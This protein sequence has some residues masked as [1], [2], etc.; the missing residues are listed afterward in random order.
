[1]GLLA[2]AGVVMAPAASVAAGSTAIGPG[3]QMTADRDENLA[4]DLDAK[5]FPTKSDE[6]NSNHQKQ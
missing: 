6:L 2:L 3:E 4:A 1:M 5:P